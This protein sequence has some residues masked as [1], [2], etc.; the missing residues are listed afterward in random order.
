MLLKSTDD[1]QPPMSLLNCTPLASYCNALLTSFNDL[2]LCCPVAI[3]PD[4]MTALQ[5]SL[6]HVATGFFEYRKCVSPSD[7]ST[8]SIT[9]SNVLFCFVLER[10][11]RLS[12]TTS[13]SDSL[14]SV[15][16]SPMS[17]FRS[18]IDAFESSF[19]HPPSHNRSAYTT[20]TCSQLYAQP[21][22][23]SYKEDQVLATS[24]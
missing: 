12:T 17:F 22:H 4:V 20:T 6:R 8:S 14:S 16:V 24:Q 9:Y 11:K 1:I 23:S 13:A 10:R 15:R 18:S 5:A 7:K 3:A 19:Q 2:R 21:C